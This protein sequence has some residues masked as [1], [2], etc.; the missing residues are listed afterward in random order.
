MR[1][2]I[3]LTASFTL[4]Q[5]MVLLA[6]SLGCCLC[7]WQMMELNQGRCTGCTVEQVVDYKNISCFNYVQ[8]WINRY[9][10]KNPTM[11]ISKCSKK[12]KDCEI[13]H[14]NWLN[15]I[16]FNQILQNNT[17]YAWALFELINSIALFHIQYKN[18]VFEFSI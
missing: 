4:P 3:I 13:N 18:S 8:I 2:K 10:N 11:W 6:L 1:L 17:V 16:I 15:K 7:A 5:T 9:V 12:C 14:H